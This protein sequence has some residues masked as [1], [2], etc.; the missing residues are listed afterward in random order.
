MA[1]TDHRRAT[2]ASGPAV[3]LVHPQLGANIGPAPRATFNCGL[4]DLPLVRPRDGWPSEASRD[5]ASG[6]GPVIDNA[7]L[8]DTV[9]EAVAD[10]HRVYATTARERHMVKR[11]VTPRQAAAEMRRLA[12]DGQ[13]VG[14][15]FGAERAGLTND[16]VAL[17][18]AIVAVPLNP[19]FS[20]LNLA[21]AVPLVGY[22]WFTAG[23]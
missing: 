8:Y 15:L 22:E 14:V 10:L 21:Q 1:G 17:A 7:R 9:E 19:S 5:A 18:D 23:Q 20:S 11:V 6:S 12:A 3:I 16:H 2:L 4:T 13:S